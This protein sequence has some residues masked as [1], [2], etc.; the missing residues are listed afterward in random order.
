MYCSGCGHLFEQGQT[1]CT[2][3]GRPA[4]TAVPP[5]PGMQFL[6]EGYAGKIRAL[7]IFWFVYAGNKNLSLFLGLAGITF[8]KAFFSGG[9]GP[10]MNGPTPPPAWIFGPAFLHLIWIFLV[11]RAVGWPSPPAGA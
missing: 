9:F 6:V 1:F 7:S 4:A 11:M 8:A 3:C 5:V 2:T 10:W